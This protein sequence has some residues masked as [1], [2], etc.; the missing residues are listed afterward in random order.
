MA[1]ERASGAQS[2]RNHCADNNEITWLR[3]YLNDLAATLRTEI[4]EAI[5]AEQQRSQALRLRDL[6]P[7]LF[8][9]VISISGYACQLI[10]YRTLFTL[11]CECKP[12]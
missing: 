1:A 4:D 11:K 9:V 12:E 5:T 8:G 6:Y 3:S 10:R 7:A 2:R